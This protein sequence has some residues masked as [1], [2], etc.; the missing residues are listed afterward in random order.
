MATKKYLT[1]IQIYKAKNE[2]LSE[3]FTELTPA[4][5]YKTIFPPETLEKK[6]DDSYRASNPIFSFKVKKEERTYFQNEI[7]FADTFDESLKKTAKNDLALCAMITYSGRKKSAKNAYKCM[8]F[9]IDLDG[10]GVKQL[11]NLFGQIE[12]LEKVPWPT[13]IANSG[14]GVH[15]YYIFQ[16]PVPLYPQVVQHLQNLKKALTG[17]VWNRDSSTYK[18]KDRQFQGIYQSFRMPGSR[19]KLGTEKTRNKYLV[20]VWKVGKPCTLEYLNGFVAKPFQ[21]PVNPDYSSWDWADEGHYSL[22]ECRLLYPDWYEKRIIKGEPTGQWVCN[23]G[24]YDWWLAKIQGFN[25]HGQ[26]NAKDGN[27]FHCIAFLYVYGIKCKIDKS[28]ID[29]DA[30]ELVE[31]FNELTKEGSDNH[32]TADDVYAAS[33]FYDRKFAKISREHI[34]FR[35]GINIPPARRNGRKQDFH[36]RLARAQK[37]VMKEMGEMNPEGRPDKKVIVK[38]WRIANPSGRKADCIRETGLSKPTVYKWWDA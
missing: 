29:A 24:L 10:V 23:R 14:H 31:P 37:S 33:H 18:P 13:Y 38:E 16:V 30:M 27:R 5:F 32:F 15:V 19:T 1:P 20:R 6:G 35:T 11:E 21:C 28:L 2:W 36:L 26:A 34:E 22:E 12:W 8:G 3:R 9:C 7:V 17:L 4:E 25:S